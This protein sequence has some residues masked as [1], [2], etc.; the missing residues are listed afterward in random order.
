MPEVLIEA[1]MNVSRFVPLFPLN[2]EGT[3]LRKVKGNFIQIM[4]K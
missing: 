3:T 1:K 4:K 2:V